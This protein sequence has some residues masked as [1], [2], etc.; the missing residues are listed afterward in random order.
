VLFRSKQEFVRD[1]QKHLQMEVAYVRTDAESEATATPY[2]I[3][4]YERVRDG[5]I[6][7]ANFVAVSLDEASILRG[8]GTKTYQEFLPLCRPCKY[9]FV[10]TATPSPNEYKELIHYAGF[11]GVMDTGEALT[12]FFQRDSE[13]A[14]NLTLYPHKEREFWLWVSSWA[15]FVQKPSDLGYDD[16]GYDLPPLNVV[17]HCV[18]IDHLKKVKTDRRTG[19]QEFFHD[20]ACS[21]PDAAREKRE[22]IDLRVA[23]MMKIINAEPDKHFILWHHLEKEREAIEKALPE[24]VSVYGDLDIETREKN[25]IDFSDGHLKYLATK[26][27]LSGSGC[28]FAA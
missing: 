12:R 25:I 11:L 24:S 23:E 2:Q 14:G 3:T 21:L 13:K 5:Q 9:R 19:Q 17:W 28:N 7:P 8:F 18:G 16:T 10:A 26:P 22:S 4:N 6:N 15:V 27:E 20:A 1:A